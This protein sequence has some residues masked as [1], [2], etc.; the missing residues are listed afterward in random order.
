MVSG[1]FVEHAVRAMHK[2]QNARSLVAQ[3]IAEVLFIVFQI[4]DCISCTNIVIFP[5]FVQ[6]NVKEYDEL[7]IMVVRMLV[8]FVFRSGIRR[9]EL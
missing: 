7:E 6:F 1:L 2:L 3:R 9:E 5:I 4:K 8:G